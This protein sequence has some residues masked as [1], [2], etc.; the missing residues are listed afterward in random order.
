MIPV[1]SQRTDLVKKHKDL[2]NL[3]MWDENPSVEIIQAFKC[4]L[5][6]GVLTKHGDKYPLTANIYVDGILGASAFKE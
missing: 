2:I 5:N 4:E 3:L 1:Y 6:Q